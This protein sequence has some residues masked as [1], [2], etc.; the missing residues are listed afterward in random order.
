M[1]DEHRLI[2]VS[3]HVTSFVGRV[4][5]VGLCSCGWLSGEEA[6]DTRIAVRFLS[7]SWEAHK[8]GA[9]TSTGWPLSPVA[10]DGDAGV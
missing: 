4:G 5:V 10:A 1:G 3:S 2:Q 8:A 7:E 9:T 6:E